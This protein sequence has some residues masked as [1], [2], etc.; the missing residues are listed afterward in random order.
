LLHFRFESADHFL[1]GDLPT[2]RKI[3]MIDT[4]AIRL[5]R[6]KTVARKLDISLSGVWLLVKNGKLKPPY[7]PA[8]MRAS[9][10]L[11]SDIDE[12]IH[13]QISNP[14]RCTDDS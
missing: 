11:E 12:F 13:S 5:L 1:H 14:Q 6:P 7:K 9:V 3:E 10:W 8:A 4:N 2:P